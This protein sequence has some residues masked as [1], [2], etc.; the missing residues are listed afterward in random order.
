MCLSTT[1]DGLPIRVH[2]E[3]SGTLHCEPPAAEALR[4]GSDII[5]CLIAEGITA[6]DKL[7]QRR[8]ELARRNILCFKQDGALRWQI[9]P[10][11]QVIAD[12]RLEPAYPYTGIRNWRG[13]L[14]ANNWDDWLYEINPDDGSVK[15]IKEVR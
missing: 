13:R 14:A 7:G 1:F 9:S 10:S 3:S 4:W 8:V 6:G 11:H 15:R 2:E 5:V 12:E